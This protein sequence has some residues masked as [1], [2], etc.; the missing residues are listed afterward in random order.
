[1][2]STENRMKTFDLKSEIDGLNIA[3]G[4]CAPERPV[5][6]L[7]LSHGMCGNKERYKELMEYMQAHD[8]VCIASDH[9]GHGDSIRSLDDLGYMYKGG[10]KAL[11]AD[12]RMVTR[13]G[14]K[15]YPGLPYFLLGHSMGSM[16]AR[17]YIKGDDSELNG[18]I[19]C[20]SPSWN[21]LSRIGRAFTGLASALGLGRTRP[22]FLQKMTSGKYNERFVNEGPEA[23]TCSNPVARKSFKE[24]PKCNFRFTTNGVY[25]LLS[26]MVKTYD[27]RG[28]KV[29]KPMMPVIFLAGSDDPCIGS[30]RKFHQAVEL[31]HKVGYR[32]ITSVLYP[33][34]RH[35]VLNEIERV[36]V[37]DDI[38]NFI[39]TS[40]QASSSY[41]KECE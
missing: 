17:V 33:G 22:A 15:E 20:G 30:E 14:Q 35:E 26:L 6:V 23:W 16:A 2:T 10:Y 3:V 12:L 8:I 34:M 24:N 38:I 11:V 9:R 18:A 28:W 36:T 27:K 32:N 40:I 7:Q 4:V 21:P 39:K 31:M 41:M 25:N 1:M 13:W 19:I 37:W 29:S 5:A